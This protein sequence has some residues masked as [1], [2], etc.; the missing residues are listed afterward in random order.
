M[1]PSSRGRSRSRRASRAGED[2]EPRRR[3]GCLRA[4]RDGAARERA[5]G[6]DRGALPHRA[7]AGAVVVPALVLAVARAATAGAG[8]AAM[9]APAIAHGRCTFDAA[10]H[11]YRLDGVVIPSVTQTLTL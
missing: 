5:R 8:G 9:S 1:T 7:Q 3:G 10:D 11:S 6:D 2:D 4:P